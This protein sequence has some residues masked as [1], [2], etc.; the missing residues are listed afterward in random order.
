[1]SQAGSLQQC[2]HGVEHSQ[3]YLPLVSMSLAELQLATSPFF[4]E[5]LQNQQL[6]LAQAFVKILLLPWVPLCMSILYVPFKTEVSISPV[7]WW[8]CT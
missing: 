6:G 4:Q 7:L 3:I 1:M 5:S 2:V 8:S